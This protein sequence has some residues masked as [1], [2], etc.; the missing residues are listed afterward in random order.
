[1]GRQLALE[2]INI[3]AGLNEPW[4]RQNAPVNDSALLTIQDVIAGP[5]ELQALQVDIGTGQAWWMTRLYFLSALA[6]DLTSIEVMIFLGEDNSFL[7][8]IHPDVVRQRLLRAY[9]MLQEYETKQ[10]ESGPAA[11]D[12]RSEVKR[13][14]DCWEQV[15]PW[16]KENQNP[17]WVTKRD[18]S[19]WFDPHMIVEAIDW[20]T[21]TTAPLQMQRLLD[22]PLRFVPVVEKRRFQ[23]VVDKQ[24]LM[25]HIARMFVREQVSRALST[26]R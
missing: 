14:A 13:R 18:L 9:P 21:G 6:A 17:I 1:M 7:G 22:W 24:A 19:Y 26:T 5:K 25:N 11:A 16:Q 3:E 4:V 10:L 2:S 20:N 23:R 15:I 8:V 12:L